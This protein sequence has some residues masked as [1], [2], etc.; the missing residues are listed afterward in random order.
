[1]EK[2][3]TILRDSSF[4]KTMVLI[5]TILCIVLKGTLALCSLNLSSDNHNQE[6]FNKMAVNTVLF[7]MNKNN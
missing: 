6:D 2:R 3:L 5:S 7:K 4:I 1:M